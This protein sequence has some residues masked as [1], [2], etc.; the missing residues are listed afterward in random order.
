MKSS[1]NALWWG[2]AATAAAAGTFGLSWKLFNYA[3]LRINYVPP[4]SDDKQKYAQRY[5]EAVD[6]LKQTPHQTWHQP[7]EQG[8]QEVIATYFPNQHA[9]KKTVIIAHG[10]R[11]NGQ[12]MAPYAKLFYQLGYNVLLPDNRAHG[13][14]S[15]KYVTFGWLDRLDYLGWINQVI[16]FNGAASEIVL[17]G[18]SMGAATVCML[19]GEKLPAQVKGI[20]S[21]CAY[22]D[23]KDELV[24][25][26]KKQ[27]H[28]PSFPI[29]P[30]VSRINVQ[31]MGYSLDEV[32]A[33]TQLKNNHLP[34][35]FIHGS[36]DE[37]VPSAMVLENY[38]AT[39]AK[40]F[41]WVVD[42]AGH[43][44]S[45]W[46]KPDEYR[47]QIVTFLAECGLG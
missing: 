2:L 41:L 43:A 15:G 30:L 32:S 26:L 23:V 20:I 21:D 12:T 29:Y 28:L 38:N 37:F 1:K 10:Y 40:K 9:N 42:G 17:F 7:L 11:G 33:V 46:L 36:N 19:S 39:T 34:I 27:F 8:S 25:L 16:Q 22:S 6:W 35:L 47:Q 4:T 24:Y 18:V 5:F 31:K 3:F 14:S 45:F 13:N 44:E